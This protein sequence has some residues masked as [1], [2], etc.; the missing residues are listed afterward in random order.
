MLQQILSIG[1]AKLEA[2]EGANQLGMDFMQPEIENGLFP[3]LFAGRFD[4]VGAFGNER[5]FSC[6]AAKYRAVCGQKVGYG[7]RVKRKLMAHAFPLNCVVL[8]AWPS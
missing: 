3:C 4:F 7:Q 1:R 2:S 8:K 6:V 5:S